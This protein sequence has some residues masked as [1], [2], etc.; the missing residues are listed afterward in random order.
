MRLKKSS[1]IVRD[2]QT[3]SLWD[4]AEQHQDAVARHHQAK[5]HHQTLLNQTRHDSRNWVSSA[6]RFIEGNQP[7]QAVACLDM[8]N[9]WLDHPLQSNQLGLRRQL[10]SAY[11]SWRAQFHRCVNLIIRVSPAIKE[12]NIQNELV[13]SVLDNLIRNALRAT[14]RGAVRCMLW[15]SGHDMVLRVSDTGGGLSGKTYGWGMGLSLIE[16]RIRAIGGSLKLENHTGVGVSVTARFNAD[17]YSL[18][19]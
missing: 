16:H 13:L 18:S 2:G 7:D 12:S 1:Y 5:S 19:N 3:P 14:H 9:N 11:C 15:Q 10:K 4:V 8:L 17:L 6:K